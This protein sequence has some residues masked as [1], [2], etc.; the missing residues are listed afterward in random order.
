M[1]GARTMMRDGV[2]AWE[3]A[4]SAAMINEMVQEVYG[5]HRP[6]YLAAAARTLG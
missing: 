6:D 3:A 4:R 2:P 1:G 5:H